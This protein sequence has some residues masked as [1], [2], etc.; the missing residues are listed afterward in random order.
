MRA[1]KHANYNARRPCPRTWAR[2]WLY[3]HLSGAYLQTLD[4][5][6]GAVYQAALCGRSF[7]PHLVIRKAHVR[8]FLRDHARVSELPLR[9]SKLITKNSITT[10]TLKC[11]LNSY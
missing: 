6:S 3:R 10:M 8:L 9:V 5:K 2:V 1:R 4:K 11:T 7:L